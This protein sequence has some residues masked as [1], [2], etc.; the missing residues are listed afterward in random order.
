MSSP[1]DVL[2]SSYEATWSATSEGRAQR[3]EVSNVIDDLFHPG[4]RI[5]DLGCGIGDDAI[6]LRERGVSVWG[7][8][9]SQEMAEI[10][11]A[12]G[13]EAHW[14]WMEDLSAVPGNL[15]G[16]LSNFGALNC[17]ARLDAVAKQLG[18]AGD[19]RRTSSRSA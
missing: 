4:D 17:V 12:R 11:R 16:A 5:L 2:A 18:A 14:R 10:S 6:H 3:N 15:S 19:C 13:V 8:D 7:I 9:S 1:F